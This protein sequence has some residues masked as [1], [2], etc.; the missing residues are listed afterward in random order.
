M[1]QKGEC[2]CKKLN[3]PYPLAYTY[4]AIVHEMPA[5]CIYD[6]C[7]EIHGNNQE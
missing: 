5:E 1:R 6:T 2:V 7:I 4:S 3:D